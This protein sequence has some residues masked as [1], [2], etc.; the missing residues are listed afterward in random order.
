MRIVVMAPSKP[1][2]K[3]G[4]RR[5]TKRHGLQVR[6][7]ETHHGMWVRQ[8]GRQCYEWRTLAELVGTQFENLIPWPRA[9]PTTKD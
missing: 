5:Y 2:P 6:V 9:W 7:P 1:R 3:T 4:D 8:N